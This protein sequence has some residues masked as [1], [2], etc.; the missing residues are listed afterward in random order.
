LDDAV[1]RRVVEIVSG[2]N[3]A[4]PDFSSPRREVGFDR[5][6]AVVGVDVNKIVFQ[7]SPS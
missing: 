7:E 5:R 4:F 6:V 2:D 1:P 3:T